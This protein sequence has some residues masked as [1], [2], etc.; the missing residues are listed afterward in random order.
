MTVALSSIVI[1][2]ALTLLLFGARVQRASNDEAGEQQTVRIVLSA[3]ENIAG[4]GRIHSVQ[5]I[6]NSWQLKGESDDPVGDPEGGPVLLQYKDGALRSGENDENVL[7]DGLQSA[8]VDWDGSLLTFQMETRQHSYRTAVFCRTREADSNSKILKTTEDKNAVLSS[9]GLTTDEKDARYEFLMTLTKQ[10]GSTGQILNR[11]DEEYEYFSQW[12]I[13]G[14]G[15]AHP[16]WNKNT[17][18]C[19]CFLSWAAQTANLN[20]NAPKFA[21]V[22]DGVAFFQNAEEPGDW[23]KPKDEET[24]T[25]TRPIPGDYI[26]FDWDKDRDPD[27]VGA[28]L[29]T[30]TEKNLVY[31]IE[32]NSGGKV[33]VH[34]YRLTDSRIMGYGVLDWK[35]QPETTEG[36]SV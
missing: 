13:G 27:H 33:A 30:D 2:A 11:A 20:S 31:T 23:R 10:Y 6:E 29:Y 24:N 5:T 35:T 14:Y 17:P 19:A 32:G 7:L 16:G 25:P 22:D 26:F 36:K 8:Y 3:L 34:S 28:V 1:A 12:Y 9:T 18:W 4:S 15:S 21:D